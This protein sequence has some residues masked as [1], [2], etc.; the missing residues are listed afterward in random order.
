VYYWCARDVQ[1]LPGR[2]DDEIQQ[3]ANIAD[4]TDANLWCIRDTC[5]SR[6]RYSWALVLFPALLLLTALVTF[7]QTCS[8]K[9]HD[10][11]DWS[12]IKKRTWAAAR[13]GLTCLTVQTRHTCDK[14][15]IHVIF[16]ACLII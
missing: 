10:D 7:P 1:L 5:R 4:N 2:A 13:N 16:A 12:H 3:K 6:S 15:D 14:Q 9:T 8:K 11:T